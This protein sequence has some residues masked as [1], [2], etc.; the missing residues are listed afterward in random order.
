MACNLLLYFQCADNCATVKKIVNYHIRHSLLYTLARKHKCSTVNVLKKYG[1]IIKTVTKQK[2]E[3]SFISSTEIL[4][5]NKSLLTK[6]IQNSYSAVS[7]YIL[8]QRYGVKKNSKT[9]STNI[10]YNKKLYSNVFRKLKKISGYRTA[11]S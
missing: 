11:K 3:F 10:Y 6:D 2:K 9:R 7:K 1:N 8:N 4:N 5:K